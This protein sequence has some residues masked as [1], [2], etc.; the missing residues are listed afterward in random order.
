MT[1]LARSRR[2]VDL[3]RLAWRSAVCPALLGA[4]ISCALPARA[5][6]EKRAFEDFVHWRPASPGQRANGWLLLLPGA[7]GLRV[8]DDERH[9]FDVASRLND[10]GWDVLLLDYVPA[11][12]AGGGASSVATGEKIARMVERAVDWL[13]RT[14]PAVRQQPG[15]LLAWSLGA[16]GAL[17]LLAN[18]DRARA[19]GV[20]ASVLFYPSNR[21][22]RAL[23]H[24]VPLM[25]L[26]GMADDVTPWGPMSQ[27]IERRVRS[28][29]LLHVHAYP[30]VHHGF[31]VRSLEQRRVIRPLRIVGPKAT[32]H[33]DVIAARDA[34]Q[35]LLEFLRAHLE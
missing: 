15:G 14:H 4:G 17:T 21:A 26:T 31:D 6:G 35:R 5:A 25:I 30:G 33:Y 34:G 10:E 22:Q 28:P 20:R 23:E 16:E 13:D 3:R 19:L 27:W 29:A 2:R 7:G 32:L 11:Y 9:Y 18:A 1:V 12:R 8:L 24:H